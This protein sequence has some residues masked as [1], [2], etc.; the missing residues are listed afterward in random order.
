MAAGPPAQ[1][2]VAVPASVKLESR[3]TRLLP[4]CERVIAGDD[5]V[6]IQAGTCIVLN[7]LKDVLAETGA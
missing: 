6:L 1:R 7:I 4:G 3:L 2:P 5:V